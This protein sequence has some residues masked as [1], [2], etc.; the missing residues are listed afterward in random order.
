MGGIE[1]GGGGG[2]FLY[3]LRKIAVSAFPSFG[4]GLVCH[5]DRSKWN[6]MKLFEQRTVFGT[7][8]S[9]DPTDLYA[10]DLI[11]LI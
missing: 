6:P 11:Q 8:P 7:T 4:N 2:I 3:Y 5:Q 10:T 9:T 1:A